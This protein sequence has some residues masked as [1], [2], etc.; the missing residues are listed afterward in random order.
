[1]KIGNLDISSFKVGSSDCK[2]YLGDVLLYPEETPVVSYKLI[3][4]YSDTTEYKV[5]CDGSSALTASEV[6]GHTTAKSAMTSAEVGEC[7]SSIDANAFYGASAL[8]SVT[9]ADNITNIGTSAFFGCSGLTS[10][11]LPGSLKNIGGTAFRFANGITTIKVP[12]GTEYIGSGAFAD[13][14]SLTGATIPAS[15][16]GTSTNLF[17]RDSRLTEVH[18]KGRTAPALGA[19]AFLQSGIQKIYIPDCDCYNS[20]AATPGMSG[21][22][23]YIY[24]ED[25]GDMCN[26]NFKFMRVH[27]TSS[28]TYPCES[29]V[30]QLSTGQTRSGTSLSVITGTASPV[31]AV[32]IGDC[33]STAAQGAFSGWTKLQQVTF[34][35][36]SRSKQLSNY[37]FRGC[38]ALKSVNLGS[39]VTAFNTNPF[40][41]C[42]SLTAMTIDRATPP[43]LT[44]AGYIPGSVQKIYIPCGSMNSYASASVWSGSTIVSKLEEV[45]TTR[46]VDNGNTACMN[47]YITY[48]EEEQAYNPNT[49]T[50]SNTGRYRAVSATTTPCTNEPYVRQA[51]S[52]AS[53]WSQSADTN[54]NVTMILKTASTQTQLNEATC[55]MN[56]SGITSISFAV[57]GV[58]NSGIMFTAEIDGEHYVQSIKGSGTFTLDTLLPRNTYNIVYK[59]LAK[60]GQTISGTNA[61]ADITWT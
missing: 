54:S 2:I 46:W 11:S 15:L 38:T 20:Y 49:S 45:C 14:S 1:M 60:D 58:N 19:D 51:C 26:T 50:W 17:L 57:T 59:L 5:E 16:T 48:T 34:V 25:T 42:T 36:G 22:T 47:G 43:S 28:Y 31:T 12:N 27:S 6:S 40:S 52:S 53:Q 32:T 3:A 9:I 10:I 37:M 30:S 29:T 7:I 18:F 8:T 21:Y 4:Q 56:V 39:N 24:S 33:Y 55:S 61:R 13:M 35:S 41:G 23:A 44:N